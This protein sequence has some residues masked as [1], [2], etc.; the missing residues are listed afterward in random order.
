MSKLATSSEPVLAILSTI[1]GMAS[2]GAVAGTSAS[3]TVPPVV[4]GGLSVTT[5]ATL[6]LGWFIR[7]YV[8]PAPG[9]HSVKA[10]AR[11]VKVELAAIL[12][13]RPADAAQRIA[14]D[15]LAVA[16]ALRPMPSVPETT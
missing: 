6:A 8:T 16:E 15:A 11:R 5:I 12:A 1:A 4:T 13:D 10:D 2:A 7:R 3:G 14:S 9:A